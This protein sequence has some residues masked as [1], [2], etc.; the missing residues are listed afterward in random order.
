MKILKRIISIFVIVIF[1]N[2]N[3]WLVNAN[4]WPLY[5]DVIITRYKLKEI[6]N[7]NNYI[8]KID[9]LINKYEN[10]SEVLKKLDL[11]T[12]NLIT[13]LDKENN[14]K[15]KDIL[16]IM[17]F[18]NS[19]SKLAK[20]ILN[21]KSADMANDAID[22]I[23]NEIESEG[24]I[25]SLEKKDDT[26]VKTYKIIAK[27][28]NTK[29]SKEKKEIIINS[30]IS[31]S[32]IKKVNDRLVEIQLNL[33]NK[34]VDSLKLITEEFEKLSNSEEKGNFK[35]SFNFD[36]ESVW[37]MNALLNFNDYT[38]KTSN[39]DSQI[40]WKIN[41]NISSSLNN[42]DTLKF[43]WS[44]LI[45]LISKDW[46]MYLLLKK[47]NISQEN[48]DYLEEM[49]EKVKNIAK[50][51]KYIKYSDKNSQKVMSIFK[52]LSP[53]K[54]ISEWKSIFEKPMFYVYKKDGDKYYLI[55]TKYACDKT[56]ELLNTFDPFNWT[57][58]SKNQYENMVDDLLKAWNI[59]ITIWNN[60][61]LWFE[62]VKN[63]NLEKLEWYI[64]FSDKYIEKICFEIWPN[65]TRYRNEFL[66][67]EYIK[68]KKLDFSLSA[69]SDDLDIRFISK[70]DKNNNFSYI[71]YYWNGASTYSNFYSNL[72]LEN[73]K[74]T[75]GFKYYNLKYDYESGKYINDKN[76]IWN[77]SWNTNNKN[78]L[79]NIK[80][81][82]I[83][84]TRIGEEFLNSNF[85][86]KNNTFSF[87]NTYSINWMK[88]IF[89]ISWIWDSTQQIISSLDLVLKMSEKEI[90]WDNTNSKKI[91]IW[92]FKD[93]FISTIKLRN[94]VISWKTTINDTYNSKEFMII[95]HSWKF[96]K[97]YFMLNNFYELK[98]EIPDI[99]NIDL[100]LIDNNNTWNLNIIIDTKNHKNNVN[101]YFDFNINKKNIIKIEIDNKSIIDYKDVNIYAPSNKDT[102]DSNEIINNN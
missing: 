97:N 66:K 73:Q 11:K 74:I 55:P 61:T 63:K 76:F 94:K 40:K 43:E 37:K 42:N 79:K 85:D 65:Q 49:I 80:I 14:P 20:W 62:W 16:I 46:N 45:D 8:K 4:F 13:K 19:K 41:T 32:E 70:L 23:I 39:F 5:K 59:Y 7:W 87:L 83:W 72:K 96:E 10:N 92:D 69:Y 95:N 86:Y 64:I 88:S 22:N 2:L 57:S 75:W 3:T 29:K 50:D 31:E 54:I 36:Q 15:H 28:E 91:Y 99:A 58:C 35:M 77:I 6:R 44:S 68:N 84:E 53:N 9:S 78:K 1:L 67:L 82:Y 90:K 21:N 102:I 26:E 81:W 60:T 12:E 101:Y 18:L 100:D 98:W 71:N 24:R 52:S 25:E 51:N 89:N 34:W 30:K 48:L 17:R 47:L 56:K 27:H 93:I 38:I 33:F